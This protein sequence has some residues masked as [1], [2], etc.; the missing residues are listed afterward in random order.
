MTG[1]ISVPSN[2]CVKQ[3]NNGVF[4]GNVRVKCTENTVQI[5]QYS[6]SDFQCAD[7]PRYEVI[8]SNEQCIGSLIND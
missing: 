3:S 5:I 6:D 4:D 2:E 7:T 1:T 8:G